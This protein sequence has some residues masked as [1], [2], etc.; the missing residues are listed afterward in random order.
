MMFEVAS[1]LKSRRKRLINAELY[2]EIIVIYNVEM[3]GNGSV[4]AQLEKAR[5]PN[6]LAFS[7][8]A[9][10]RNCGLQIPSKLYVNPARRLR[11]FYP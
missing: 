7:I 4:L 10:A 1:C 5:L 6:G 2:V 9:S 11:V 3:V 8:F